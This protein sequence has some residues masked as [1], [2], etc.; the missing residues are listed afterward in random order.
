MTSAVFIIYDSDR[1]SR[2]GG[3]SKAPIRH[4]EFLFPK[5]KQKKPTK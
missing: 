4:C 1:D 2:E 5:N 3:V